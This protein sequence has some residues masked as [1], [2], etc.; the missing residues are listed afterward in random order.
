MRDAARGR[1]RRDGKARPSLSR[2]VTVAFFIAIGFRESRDVSCVRDANSLNARRQ[3][4]N[5]E[6]TRV[7]SK[8][9]GTWDNAKIEGDDRSALRYGAIVA[10]TVSPIRR[11]DQVNVADRDIVDGNWA[12]VT[13]EEEEP[14]GG[15]CARMRDAS[16]HGGPFDGSVTARAAMATAMAP[17]DSPTF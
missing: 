9:G 12:C 16:T 1:Q 15:Q 5:L 3:D 7:F 17:G 13:Y 2:P 11:R 4:H 8:R 6:V 14:V 10:I